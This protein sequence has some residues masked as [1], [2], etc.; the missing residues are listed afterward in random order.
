MCDTPATPATVQV[1][2][3][4]DVG[5]EANVV[6]G[7]TDIKLLGTT[8]E[9]VSLKVEL[10]SLRTDSYYKRV[11]KIRLCS[12]LCPTPFRQPTCAAL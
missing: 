6:N 1:I 4:V 5:T 9:D 3:S 11:A 2:H 10:I 12:Y 8:K 7:G